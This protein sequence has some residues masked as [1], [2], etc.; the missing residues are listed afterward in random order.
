MGGR[1][2]MPTNDE[3]KELLDNT[4]SSWVTCNIKHEGEHTTLLGRLFVSKKDKTKKL[5]FPAAGCWRIDGDTNSFYE[6]GQYGYY[7]SSQSDSSYGMAA[8]SINI[9]SNNNSSTTNYGSLYALSVR[10]VFNDNISLSEDGTENG[11]SYIDLGLPSGIKWATYNIG[12]NHPC[13][14][15]LLFQWGRAD[16]YAYGDENH[17]F[18]IHENSFAPYTTTMSGKDYMYEEHL[19]KEDDTASINMGGR[20]RMPTNNEMQELLNNTT[21]SWVIY[22]VLHKGKHISMTGRLFVSKSD[23]SKKLFMPACGKWIGYEI[24]TGAGIAPRRFVDKTIY[25]MYWSS[26]SNN[27]HGTNAHT[28]SISKYDQNYTSNDT[29]VNGCSVRGVFYA[30]VLNENG[31]E[32]GHEWVDLGLPSGTK[33]AT[34]NV[35]ATTP[36]DPGLLFQWG[37]VDGYRY[38]D[39]NHQFIN[40]DSYT[41][42]SGKTYIQGEV[43]NPEDDAATVNMGGRWHMP[44]K[45]DIEELYNNTF[46]S[47]TTCDIEHE[48]EHIPIPGR[49]FVSL[50]D[51]SKKLFI[52]A[53]GY[54]GSGAFDYGDIQDDYPQCYLWTSNA[55]N[56][57]SSYELQVDKKTELDYISIYSLGNYCAC[58]VRG[59][60]K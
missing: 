18:I 48:G 49:L 13:E 34:C 29:T 27:Y 53:G 22:D 9:A 3:M 5:F 45:E 59:V 31:I 4:T 54:R 51:R 7:W 39:E 11:Y 36:C 23:K 8:Y 47:W 20:W 40:Y 2:R 43:L 55:Y 42:L 37:R 44:T 30:E 12:A 57:T 35:G 6:K 14:P 26:H 41:T 33:W 52:P 50:K 19:I 1:W 38:G 15:G 17:Q 28:I 58:S 21:S 46:V 16:G 56:S 32:N 24:D 25:G 60:C 10:G